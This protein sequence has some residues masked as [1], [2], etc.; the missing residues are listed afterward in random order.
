M[1]IEITELSRSYLQK[2]QK[3]LGEYFDVKEIISYQEIIEYALYR[4]SEQVQSHYGELIMA[5]LGPFE[6]FK[7][8]KN[9]KVISHEIKEIF[10]DILDSLLLIEKIV[11][12]KHFGIN[13]ECLTIE[14]IA[15]ELQT[16][17]LKVKNI[18]DK[19]LRKL[20]HPTRGDRLKILTRCIN[21]NLLIKDVENKITNQI[22]KPVSKRVSLEGAKKL[23]FIEIALEQGTPSWHDW[24]MNGVGSSDAAVITNSSPYRSLN[25]LVK[26]KVSKKA[27]SF[28][29][30]AMRD[31]K[32]L[33]SVARR[34]FEKNNGVLFRPACLQSMSYEWLRASVDGI[35]E[36]NNAVIEIK[37]GQ[38]IYEKINKKEPLPR[39][40]YAQLQH[41]LAV[42]G[43]EKIGFVCYWKNNNLIHFDVER[44][45]LFIEKLILEGTKFWNNV[46]VERRK[47]D[48]SYDAK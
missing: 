12:T 14:E 34:I 25:S 21:Q 35:S 41:I 30:Q 31:G 44:D 8:E 33:E 36:D 1:N 40:Y 23:G 7:F 19:A 48:N 5:I 26:E 9:N 27:S 20:R 24:R 4:T 47:M 13:C 28:E 43:L 46:V 11:I 32:E 2:I 37:C 45:E 17:K 3:E 10:E 22:K 38:K 15:K 29:N 6:S 39:Y 42:T 18:E 16:T